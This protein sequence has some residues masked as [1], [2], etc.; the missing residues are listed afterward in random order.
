MDARRCKGC[1]AKE[2]GECW[3]A[4]LDEPARIKDLEECPDPLMNT[5]YKLDDKMKHLENEFKKLKQ[6]DE[7]RVDKKGV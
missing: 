5:I 7:K 2:K 6:T 4:F 1:N 3:S